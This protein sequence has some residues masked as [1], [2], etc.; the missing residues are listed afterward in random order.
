MSQTA[1]APAPHRRR[2]YTAEDM[3]AIFQLPSTDQAYRLTVPGRYKLERRTRWDAD[4]VDAYID[5][6]MKKEK[7]VA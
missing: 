6:Q 2:S 4:V 5:E 3:A 1:T 7:K